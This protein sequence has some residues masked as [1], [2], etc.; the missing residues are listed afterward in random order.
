MDIRNIKSIDDL[1]RYF[2]EELNWNIDL[3]DF[4]EID[5]ITY[6]FDAA[7]IGLK[8]DAFAKISSFR[9]LQPFCDEQK[10]GIFCVEF[11]SNKFEVSALRK[12]LSGLIPKRRN[13]AEHAVWSQK[14]LL[15]LCFWGADN[16]RTIG[17]AHFEDKVA[18]LP[19]IKMI[20]CAPA[21]EDF[22]QIRT[23]EDRIGHLSWVKDVT[24]T[25][26]WYDQWSSAF[27]TAYHQVI[28]D[29]ASLTVKLAAEAQAIRDRILDIYAVETHDGYVH[30]LFKD[31]KDNLIHDMT[32]QQFADMYA[33]TVVYGLFSARCMDKT[34]DSFNVKEAIA[35][36]PNTNP[37]LKR[38]MEECL[39]EGS[40]RHLTFDE[41][42]VAN[43]V[44]I[45]THTNTDLILADF[46]RQT[47]GGRE[48]PVIHFYEEFLTAYDKAQKV[49][50]GV[51]Y[52]PQPVVNFIVRAVDSILKTEFG[53]A[54]GLASEETKTVKYMR[55]KIRGQGMT[56]DTK[57]VPAVQILDP[58]TGTGTF[59]RQTILQIYDNFRAKHS[60]ESEAQI[61]K[62]WNEY[63]PKHLLPRLNGFELM[64]APYAVTHMKLAMV[65]KDTGY[66][67]GGDH[68]LN[69]FLTNSL[70]EANGMVEVFDDGSV[71]TSM[72]DDPL[73]F[74]S[75][76]ANQ[77]KRNN[78]INVIIGNPPYSSS[79]ANKNAW[80]D[81]LMQIYKTE[82]GGKEKLKEQKYSIDSDE[83]KFMRFA[84]HL[85]NSAGLGVVAYINPHAYLDKPTFRG[86]RWQLLKEF[87]AIYIINLHG[88]S[89]HQE[90][91]PDGGKDENVF[92]I[93][94]G[95]C[96]NVFVKTGKNSSIANVF[97]T[98]LYG[99]R[100]IKYSK[101]NK[102][103]LKHLTFD[104]PV[105]EPPYYLFVPN[106]SNTQYYKGFCLSDLLVIHLEGIQTGK[107]KLVLHNTK[108]ELDAVI[109]DILSMGTESIRRKYDLGNDGRD[110]TVAWAK[111]DIISH[112][113]NDGYYFKLFLS[114]FNSKWSF[115]TGKS[116][117]FIKCCRDKVSKEM[118]GHNNL[119]LALTR[120]AMPQRLYSNFM[121]VDS[122]IVGR[123]I[124][125]FSTSTQLFPI[126]LYTNTF[127]EE[128][129]ETNFNK[130]IISII[131][132]KLGL[133]FK[134][135][136]EKSSSYYNSVNLVDY[137]YAILNSMK[138]RTTYQEFL[139]RDFPYIPYPTNQET[140]WKLVEIGG[141]LRECHLMQTE[142]DTAAYSFVGDGTNE[143]VKPEY[144]N[145]RVYISKTQ[146]FDNVPQAQWEQYIGGYQPL[147]KW[148]K[149]RKK[150]MLSAE[151][152][153]HYKK[154]IAALRLTE[155]LMAEI[156][157]VVEF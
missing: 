141:K 12:I 143:V 83:I 46:N 150:T 22:T 17:I 87:D 111:E 94:Q 52:T 120:N 43:V 72:F 157:Q 124:G 149:D 41:L 79:S 113:P 89:N 33:Q 30:K 125:D 18:G 133:E 98:D 75:A 104:V 73:A 147:Q 35:C 32:K 15:F 31:F 74:E 50:R 27:V 66:D 91:T 148:L 16:N 3:D 8:A 100:D 145:G 90:T 24:D 69:V 108:E 129:R 13:A 128:N 99:T 88:N 93:Q 127:G 81:R 118:I 1:I 76:E 63:V 40:E 156:D 25:Q 134:N 114:P 44:E 132:N 151:D 42:E 106:S 28:R 139:C 64:M 55:E 137:V 23:F 116:S 10:W 78:G 126:F 123:F 47:G 155:E 107:D 130:N 59:L 19:Q 68:R 95:V 97:Y 112:Y 92:D 138:Y 38:L 80:L 136:D 56:E 131:S 102:T 82:P 29:S 54:D 14:D 122:C 146:Y 142:F 6:D 71:M 2:T 117:G 154:I 153:E 39:G 77:A 4:D 7:D 61:K 85:I 70:E 121:I 26:A 96:I 86:M 51:Y 48:D 36:I 103:E 53:L 105:S 140:F 109:E 45:L 49:Q 57:E 115:Y 101:L 65:L 20:S 60:G 11:D 37:F 135:T 119:G 9:Q 62:A 144:K 84:Q 67:F 21:V 34:Q 152:I 5:D 110:W 58:A